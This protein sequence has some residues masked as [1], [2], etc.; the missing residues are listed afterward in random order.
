MDLNDQ[1]M[2][3]LKNAVPDGISIATTIF[4]DHAKNAE[5]WDVEGRRFIDFGGGIGVVNTGH[6]NEAI[7]D[8]VQQ[9][10]KNYTHTAFQVVPYSIY[11]ELAETM[12]KITPGNFAKKTMLVTTGAEAVE[13]TIK[14]ARMATKRQVVIAFTGGFHGRTL[15]AAGLTGKVNPNKTNLGLISRDI[16]HVPYPAKDADFKKTKEAIENIFRNDVEPTQIAAFIFEPVQGEGGFYQISQSAV[17]WLRELCDKHGI[18]LIADEVQTGF[19]RTGKMFAMEHYSVCADLMTSAKSLAGGFPLASVTGRKELMDA[20]IKGALGGTYAGNPLGI[21]AALKVIEIM[22]QQNLPARAEVLGR[23]IEDMITTITQQIPYLKEF[24]RLGVMAAL[25]IVDPATQQPSLEITK[26]IQ[27]TAFANGLILLTCG[28]DGNV[29]RIL[30]PLT[31]ED[32]VFNEALA[33]LKKSLM[34]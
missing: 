25:E 32:K 27:S 7:L 18:V 29:I 31:I 19:G 15:F 20:P 33:I 13:N 16:F 24:R 17:S 5:L 4:V 9:Q 21:A 3:R 22:Q 6:C 28:P 2:Q 10:M 14:I 34:A 12:N 11:V 23:K 8:A 26:K 30:T 1:W